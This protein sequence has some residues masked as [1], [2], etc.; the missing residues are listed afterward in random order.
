MDAPH[1]NGPEDTREFGID[2]DD[3]RCAECG[4]A[5]NRPCVSDCAC[6]YCIQRRARKSAAEFDAAAQRKGAA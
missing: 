1:W 5:W 2:P 6:T 4:V 3:E